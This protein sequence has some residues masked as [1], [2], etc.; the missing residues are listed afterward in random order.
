MEKGRCFGSLLSCW[1]LKGNGNGFP[2]GGDGPSLESI[3]I[4]CWTNTYKYLSSVPHFLL[5][6]SYCRHQHSGYLPRQRLRIWSYGTV[7]NPDTKANGTFQR[8]RGVAIAWKVFASNHPSKKSG[9]HPLGAA[10][11]SWKCSFRKAYFQEA[12]ILQGA[13]KWVQDGTYC[14]PPNQLETWVTSSCL[15]SNGFFFRG[16]PVT[17]RRNAYLSQSVPDFRSGKSCLVA[18]P[19]PTY[20]PRIQGWWYSK[21]MCSVTYI[22]YTYIL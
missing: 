7:W 21:M 13:P 14:L 5:D 11:R 6:K 17:I 15:G 10:S 16:Y 4:S 2:E 18:S 20:N 19:P 8:P 22:I 12:K 3:Y 9:E 1:K